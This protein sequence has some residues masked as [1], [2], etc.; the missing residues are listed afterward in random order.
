MNKSR[1]PPTAKGVVRREIVRIVTPGTIMEDKTLQSSANNFIMSVA[2]ETLQDGGQRWAIAACDL[3][4][5]E[6]YVT[7]FEADQEQL[8]EE[9]NAYDPAEVIAE[10]GLQAVVH[11][12][13][14]TDEQEDADHDQRGKGCG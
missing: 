4:T 12:F 10:G 11:R 1:I 5:G 7:D 9:L 8:Y 14:R 6:L 13:Q 3:S 2:E